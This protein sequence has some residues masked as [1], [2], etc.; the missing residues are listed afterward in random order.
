MN[1]LNFNVTVEEANLLIVA[2][3]ELPFK[4]SSALIAKLQTQAQP[5]M[6]PKP[7]PQ[8]ELVKKPDK[9]E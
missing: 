4:V 9:K 7:E 8:M 6:Q 1:V 3:S 5:Q 2:L